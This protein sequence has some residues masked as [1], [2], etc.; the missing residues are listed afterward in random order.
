MEPK[1]QQLKRT[2]QKPI[3]VEEKDNKT[4]YVFDKRTSFLVD[5]K[6]KINEIIGRG[7]YGIVAEG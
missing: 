1:K 2:V 5:N 6:Y 4:L 7:G 3:R